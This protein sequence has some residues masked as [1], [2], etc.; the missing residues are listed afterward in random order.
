MKSIP[1]GVFSC[2][3]KKR[4]LVYYYSTRMSGGKQFESE[5]IILKLFLLHT[6]QDK[7]ETISSF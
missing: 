4:C 3:F 6:E 2:Y 5:N 7:L 1:A